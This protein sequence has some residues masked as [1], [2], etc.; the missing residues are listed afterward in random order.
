MYLSLF[1]L[2]HSGVEQFSL[3]NVACKSSGNNKYC[4]TIITLDVDLAD[5]LV[6]QVVHL[7]LLLVLLDVCSLML[8]LV[9]CCP[10]LLS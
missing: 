7:L 9:L 4:V 5:D 1:P 10:C 6:P 3:P 2:S 8:L